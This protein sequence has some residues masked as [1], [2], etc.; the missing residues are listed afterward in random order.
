MCS[1]YYGYMVNKMENYPNQQRKATC[2]IMCVCN[3]CLVCDIWMNGAGDIH[4]VVAYIC[5]DE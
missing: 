2:F 4:K 3:V 1:T 5:N